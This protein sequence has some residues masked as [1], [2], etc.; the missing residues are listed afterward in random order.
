[1]EVTIL[2]RQ[3]SRFLQSLVD[4]LSIFCAF[5]FKLNSH[6]R[7]GKAYLISLFSLFKSFIVATVSMVF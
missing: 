1:M 3:A 4:Y 2:S 6:Q 5:V 7:G